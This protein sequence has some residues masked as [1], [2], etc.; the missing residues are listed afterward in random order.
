MNRLIYYQKKK[1]NEGTI[2][3]NMYP[4][5]YKKNNYF[6]RGIYSRSTMMVHY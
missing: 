6:D 3:K 2:S 1:K 5:E 4:K